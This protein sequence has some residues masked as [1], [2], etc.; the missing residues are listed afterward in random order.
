MPN[1]TCWCLVA[2]NI[3]LLCNAE[4]QRTW[5]LE[6]GIAAHHSFEDL[7]QHRCL[8]LSALQDLGQLWRIFGIKPLAAQCRLPLYLSAPITMA[9]LGVALESG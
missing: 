5:S 2:F 1:A 9:G 7:A 4:W 6:F 8:A 3:P